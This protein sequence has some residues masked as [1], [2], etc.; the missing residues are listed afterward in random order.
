MMKRI[1]GI[2]TMCGVLLAMMTAGGMD[3]G[4]LTIGRIVVQAMISSLL[5]LCGAEGKRVFE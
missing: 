3:E 5:I 4:S 1:F 2:M